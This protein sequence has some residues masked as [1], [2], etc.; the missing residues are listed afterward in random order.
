MADMNTAPLILSKDE[1]NELFSTLHTFHPHARIQDHLSIL[2]FD[3][4]GFANF[5]SDERIE[6]LSYLRHFLPGLLGKHRGTYANMWG[7][8]L[9]AVF[10]DINDGLNCGLELADRMQSTGI[11]CR[12]GMDYGPI[13]IA[14]N[15]TIG[16]P[17]L[18]GDVV[19]FAAR[20][21][22]SAPLGAF[23]VSRSVA[24]N[25]NVDDK[26]FTFTP[27]TIRLCKG[28]RRFPKDAVVEAFLVSRRIPGK[29]RQI[30]NGN[31]PSLKKKLSTM[32][33][34]IIE[35]LAV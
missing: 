35:T 11:P 29:I 28:T 8:A 20:L 31:S 16:L 33:V 9:R 3:I 27:L 4:A 18:D 34:G 22:S 1:R 14:H 10:A 15:P 13:S 6:K 21:E 2:F 5:T 30:L 19:N 24:S 17:D 23:V 25:A 7:D 32:V 26:Q 12:F